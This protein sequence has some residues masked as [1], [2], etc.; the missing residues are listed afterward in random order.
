[1]PVDPVSVTAATT[2]IGGL[3]V[4]DVLEDILE[5]LDQSI[6]NAA[7][8]FSNAAQDLLGQLRV[9]L[10]E[11]RKE[12]KRDLSELVEKVAEELRVQLYNLMLGAKKLV[13][14]AADELGKVSD[15]AIRDLRQVLSRTWFYSEI[16]SLDE[17]DGTLVPASATGDW[18]LRASGLNLGFDSEDIE[19]VVKLVV[20]VPDSPPFIV[21][22][23][24]LSD[25][26]VEFALPAS[27]LK[28][29]RRETQVTFLN[30]RLDILIKKDRAMWFDKK[31]RGS[32]PFRIT[33]APRVAGELFVEATIPEFGWVKRPDLDRTFSNGL[34][35]GHAT[36][37]SKVG[38]HRITRHF[39]IARASVPPRVGDERFYRG[40]KGACT[41][42][43]CSHLHEFRVSVTN[44]GSTLDVYTYNNSHAITVRVIGRVERFEETSSETITSDPLEIR[45]GTTL[46]VTASRRFSQLRIRG[47]DADFGLIELGVE[48]DSRSATFGMPSGK[49]GGLEFVGTRTD[50]DQVIYM[51]VRSEVRS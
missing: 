26:T 34:P 17:I 14:L 41:G 25:H 5:D 37:S 9:S 19:S 29:N 18:K 31:Y 46:E 27:M 49:F 40:D 21:T 36:S 42:G 32:Q 22:G 15:E 4:K 43:G 11:L 12:L 30:A 33:F 47:R 38:H 7:V 8:R 1:M 51:F 44:N 48:R 13:T 10:E 28:E 16:Y 45:G 24:E 35:S 50:G 23:A 3:V 2:A 39:S 6:E 20:E